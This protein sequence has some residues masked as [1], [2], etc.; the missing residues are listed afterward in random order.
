VRIDEMTGRDAAL[1]LIGAAFN[2]RFDTRDRLTRQFEAATRL[3][4]CVPVRRLSY[5]RLLS[6]LPDVVGAVLADRAVTAHG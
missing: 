6:R 5:P 4:E 2:Q 1:V 3:A